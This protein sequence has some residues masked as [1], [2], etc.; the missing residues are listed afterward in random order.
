MEV[1]IS[2]SDAYL[3][4]TSHYLFEEIHVCRV[5]LGQESFAIKLEKVIQLLLCLEPLLQLMYIHLFQN[6][7]LYHYAFKF[8]YDCASGSKGNKGV[9]Y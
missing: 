4:L 8:N 3:L 1:V 2:E 9:D 6:S 5:N 7:L